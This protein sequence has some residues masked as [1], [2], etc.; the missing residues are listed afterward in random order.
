MNEEIWK[1][2]PGYDG[3]YQ[4]SNFGNVMSFDRIDS[5]GRNWKGRNLK[6]RAKSGSGYYFVTLCVNSK[7]KAY[8][9]HQLVA[10]AFLNHEAN[11]FKVVV[12]HID[13]VKTNN[14]L[15]NIQL[16]SNRENS[17]KENKGSSKYVGVRKTKYG[18]FRSAIRFKGKRFWLGTFKTEIEASNAYQNKLK[19][20]LNN[21]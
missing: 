20:I 8:Y 10:M 5:Q 12:D 3:Y 17:V 11:S 15:S 4:V 2:I 9:V 18:T 1:D 14:K 21:E 7:S 19:E 16:I 13:N 6:I